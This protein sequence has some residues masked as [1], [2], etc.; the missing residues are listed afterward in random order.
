[1]QAN[2]TLPQD[3]R[4]K[5]FKCQNMTVSFL[6]REVPRPSFSLDLVNLNNVSHMKLLGLTIQSDLKWNL[7]ITDIVSGAARR[8]YTLCILKKVKVPQADMVAV[9]NC[10]VRPI[11][12]YGSQVWHTTISKKQCN[13]I[14]RIQKRVCR[15]ILGHEYNTYLDAIAKLNMSTLESRWQTLLCKFGNKLLNST[16]FRHML[17]PTKTNRK[18]LRSDTALVVPRCRTE[19]Y[20][21]STIP[22]LARILK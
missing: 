14:E 16:K 18:Q 10:Y 4:T 2:F 7:H 3:G 1:M 13:D 5:Q 15:I 12:E 22:V 8:L 17:P 19:R 6:K 21:N 20:S 9:F 11:L